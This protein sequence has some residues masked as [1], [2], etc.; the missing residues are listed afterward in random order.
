[1]RISLEKS[2]A[3]PPNG[4]AL[5]HL[6]IE[7]IGVLRQMRKTFLPESITDLADSLRHSGQ[8]NPGI[9]VALEKEQAVSYI[10]SINQTWGTSYR[11][12]DFSKS[13][14]PEK[15]KSF[16]FFLVAGERRYRGCKAA[17]INK[18]Y[19]QLRFG[20]S[21]SDAVSLQAQENLH[22]AVSHDEAASMFALLWRTEKKAN[23]NL[24]IAAFAKRVGKSQDAIRK[25]VRFMNLPIAIQEL[26][27]PNNEFK[28]G[29][30]YGILCELAR[31][32]EAYTEHKVA[33]T[34]L[35][36][37]QYAYAFVAQQ[38]TVKATSLLVS[39]YVEQLIRAKHGERP[40]FDLSLQDV[41][42][43]TKRHLATGLEQTLRT[44]TAHLR[45]VARFHEDPHIGK[46]ASEGAVQGVSR[47]LE[48]AN[49]LAPQIVEGIR[50]A[51]GAHGV[52]RKFPQKK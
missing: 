24:T 41:V 36:L 28:K 43:G 46:V 44:G 16:F 27:L 50:G 30:P 1:M 5:V 45:A 40:L 26:V 20:M 7:S 29:V 25:A 13:Y 14:I 9:V 47:T 31:L 2:R 52:I 4:V 51:R 15:K 32:Q 39:E 21:F 6:P 23:P 18:Y 22:E 17:T 48:T 42:E 35:E 12:E 8:L 37:K 3:T 38:K 19:C 49:E 33:L 11:I 10:S 34:V